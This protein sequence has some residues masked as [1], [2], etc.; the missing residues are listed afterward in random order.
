VESPGAVFAAAPA[1]EDS[2]KGHEMRVSD[3]WGSDV[4]VM[5]KQWLYCRDR[6]G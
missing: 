5:T 6:L 1:E 3:L 4:A 2:G